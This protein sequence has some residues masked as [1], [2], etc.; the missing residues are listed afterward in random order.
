MATHQSETTADV[1]VVGAGGAGVSAATVA[2]EAGARVIVVD[3]ADVVGGTAR[4]AGGGTT[5]AGTSLQRREGIVDSPEIALEDWVAW[6]GETVDVEWAERYLRNSVSE[7][8]EGLAALGITWRYVKVQDGNSVPRWH[9]PKG[10]GLAVMDVLEA[11]ARQHDAIAWRLGTRVTGLT[12]EGGRV[13]GVATDG[14]DG[15]VEFRARAVVMASGGFANNAEMVHEHAGKARGAERILLGGGVGA[16][17]EGHRVLADVG[18]QFVNMD[19]VWMR[20][21]GTPD[22]E[23]PSGKRGLMVR[24]LGG[25]VWLNQA[26]QRFHNE[27]LRGGAT[28]T[29]ALFA[30][31]PVTCW[32]IIDARI[33]ATTAV[34]DPRYRQGTTAI[35]ERIQ[36]FLDTSPY[37]AKGDTVEEVADKAGIDSSEAAKSIANH[38][39]WLTAGLD[40]DPDHGRP[41][42][43]LEPL[44]QPPYYAIQFFPL[45]RKNLG[46]VRTDLDC[47]VLDAD[48]RPIPGLYAAGEVAG[49]A[50]GRINGKAALEGTMFGPSIFSGRV[51]GRSVVA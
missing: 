17:G 10:G 33:A 50:G 40:H 35:R 24:G 11:N 4:T 49:M 27:A 37:V 16:R 31:R 42:A 47:Q 22:F 8:Y 20:A 23:D 32:S 12:T 44:D 7:V 19:A 38:N 45:A 51:A 34:A 14:P 3:P 15:S 6:G 41:L 2:A 39:R 26:G 36:Y 25:D 43:R 13:V 9:S 48:D 18:A 5:F 1:I 46:G 29:P 21:H 28:G 30:Q